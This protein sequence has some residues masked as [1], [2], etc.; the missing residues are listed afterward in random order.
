MRHVKM[1]FSL[2]IAFLLVSGGMIAGAAHAM[3]DDTGTEHAVAIHAG[4][5]EDFDPAPAYELGAASP[6]F[7]GAVPGA[8]DDD[9]PALIGFPGAIPVATAN[10]T[11]GATFDDLFTTDPPHS[12]VVHSGPE[13]GD[14][15]LTCG[16]LG[17]VEDDG[18]IMVALQPVGDARFAGVGVFDEDDAGF[19]GL[20]DEEVNL[21]VYVVTLDTSADLDA[22]TPEPGAVDDAGDGYANEDWLVDVSWI[23]ERFNPEDADPEVTQNISIVGVFPLEE[24]P[25]QMLPASRMVES[26]RLVLTDTSDEAIE[27]W[28]MQVTLTALNV[29]P[30][31]DE[32]ALQEDDVLVLYDDGTFGAAALWWT[33][34]YLGHPN[35]HML[36]GGLGAW[37]EQS[38][39]V[40]GAVPGGAG[41]Q[42]AAPE[43]VPEAFSGGLNTD[44]LATVD[45]VE[46]ILEDSNV[47]LVDTRSPDEYAAGH[48]PGAVNIP[49]SE[50][51][52]SGDNPV[53]AD[54][55]QLRELYAEAGVTP[56]ARVI[57]YGGDDFG[58]YG[59]YFTLGLL[60]YEDIAVYPGGWV[61]WS[62][63]PALPRDSDD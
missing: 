14:D 18:R 7:E 33:L 58:A 17:G 37:T 16:E 40:D 51:V 54:A 41:G 21:T 38:E 49:V 15:A 35:K 45:E 46:S 28:R 8:P 61:E 13:P 44:V 22:A 5:C 11:L 29:A 4:T 36:N 55:E 19:L 24:Q 26:E 2:A 34:D 48:I 1:W 47:V 3:Q 9:Q 31:T 20:G 39:F 42:A 57:T 10:E 50:N 32:G 60:G 63:F 62:Q 6:D 59:A 43:E 23:D 52:E 12:L 53:W 30:F 27:E 56:E 25:D